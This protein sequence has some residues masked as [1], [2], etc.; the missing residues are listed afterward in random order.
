MSCSL[1]KSYWTNKGT[2]PIAASMRC[3]YEWS[4][5]SLSVVSSAAFCFGSADCTESKSPAP[6]Y[7]HT[8]DD[9]RWLP[10]GYHYHSG[11]YN[12][13]SFVFSVWHGENSRIN[14]H[15][16]VLCMI[17]VSG[18]SQ[19]LDCN[20]GEVTVLLCNT[21]LLHFRHVY[22]IM[23]HENAQHASIEKVY[24]SSSSPLEI[25]A[26]GIWSKDDCIGCST[27]TC[28]CLTRQY[29]SHR[30]AGYAETLTA[31]SG[32]SLTAA[33][34]DWLLARVCAKACKGFFAD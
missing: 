5:R 21:C 12:H 6:A 4:I 1:P 30:L 22:S 2:R 13:F 15:D 29:Q 14:T 18:R 26:I 16:D 25:L 24:L 34:R 31:S 20:W 3:W 8:K 9:D 27:A 28:Y 23:V 33:L 7:L 10:R 11:V 17:K 32:L 19:L